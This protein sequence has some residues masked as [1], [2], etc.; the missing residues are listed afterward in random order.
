VAMSTNYSYYAER[1]KGKVSWNPF[2]G[3]F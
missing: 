1:V 3:L 2:E